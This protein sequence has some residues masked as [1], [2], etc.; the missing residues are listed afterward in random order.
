MLARNKHGSFSLLQF[1]VNLIVSGGH[2]TTIICLPGSC[3][4][5]NCAGYIRSQYFFQ[6]LQKQQGHQKRPAMFGVLVDVSGSMR[7]AYA[8]DESRDA[9]VS[10]SHAIFTTILN[11]VKKECNWGHEIFAGAFGLALGSVTTCDLFGLL[12]KATNVPEELQGLK[13]GVEAM[14]HIAEEEGYGGTVDW[15]REEL[16]EEMAKDLFRLMCIKPSI[17][18]ELLEKLPSNFVAGVANVVSIVVPIGIRNSE[19]F[20]Y[21]EDL[22]S[23]KSEFMEEVVSDIQTPI[24]QHAPRVVELLQEL[25]LDPDDPRS[26]SSDSVRKNIDETLEYIEP[27]I[28][29]GTPMVKAMRDA[30]GVFQNFNRIHP[31]KQMT[32]LLL[33]DGQ[34]SDGDPKEIAEQIKQLGVTIVTCFL[35]D[36]HLDDPYRCYDDSETSSPLSPVLLKM[37]STKHNNDSP[38][39]YLADA[40]WKLPLSGESRLYIEANTL[41][42]V[43]EVCEKVVSELNNPCRDGVT[44]ILNVVGV[45]DMIGESFENFQPEDQENNSTCYA[46]AIAAV[47]CFAMHRIVDREGGHPEFRTIR[48]ELIQEFGNRGANVFQVLKRVCPRYRLRFG[49]V[50]ESVARGAL[51]YRRPLVATFT[52]SKKKR[53]E[54]I[55]FYGKNSGGILQKENLQGMQNNELLI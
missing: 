37:S 18:R 29:G 50:D 27:Y 26:S 31:D 32:L 52:Y 43:N 13:P 15:I 44:D 24:P 3:V 40:G 47:M 30:L 22:V 25:N 6:Q 21:A 53:K 39:Y 1:R 38:M 5:R 9:T 46:H 4:R 7:S 2:S 12:K 17:K 54:F 19:A 51:N 20:Q 36:Q 49:R 33:T 34:S 11:I 42:I 45:Q 16:S 23:R 8:V 14:V 41:E 28:Y 35:T 55:K 10:R 48:E